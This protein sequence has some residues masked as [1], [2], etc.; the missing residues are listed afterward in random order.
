MPAWLT[1][2]FVERVQARMRGLLGQ[3]K[4]TPYG[5]EMALPWPAS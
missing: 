1:P 4:A 5:A 3:W 2:A